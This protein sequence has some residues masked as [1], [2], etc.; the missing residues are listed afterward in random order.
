MFD[1]VQQLAFIKDSWFVWRKTVGD[2]IL[3]YWF[4]LYACGIG[5]RSCWSVFLQVAV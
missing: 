3:I 4:T 1:R 2:S 5:S